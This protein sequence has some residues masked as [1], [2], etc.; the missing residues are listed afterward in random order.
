MIPNEIMKIADEE[1]EISIVSAFLNENSFDYDIVRKSDRKI[2]GYCGIILKL[3]E[4]NDF[5]GNIEYEIF[6]QYRG[7]NYAYKATKL[8]GQVALYFGVDNLNISIRPD[9]FA[10]IRIAQKLGAR[11]ICIKSLPNSVKLCDDKRQFAVYN[12]KIESEI[13]K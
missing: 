5:L 6:E 13:T 10:S 8:L 9:N 4:E 11:F 12:W 1:I 7:N 2:I 3:T